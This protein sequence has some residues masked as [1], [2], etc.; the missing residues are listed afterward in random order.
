MEFNPLL[1]EDDD[2]D[3]ADVPTTNVV[4]EP[5]KEAVL[6]AIDVA[7]DEF[8][9]ND[10]YKD[11]MAVCLM[12][13]K[14]KIMCAP[15]D[16]VGICFYGTKKN[17][18]PNNFQ[19]IYFL[20][21]FAQN[22]GVDVLGVV[23]AEIER[24]QERAEESFTKEYGR[25]TSAMLSD[26]FWVATTSF[27]LAVGAG[28]TARAGQFRKRLLFFTAREFPKNNSEMVNARAND[29]REQ[30]IEL[31]LF[32]LNQ[33][34]GLWKQVFQPEEIQ[35]ED[36]FDDLMKDLR[37]KV[38]KKRVVARIPFDV[39]GVEIMVSVY[40]NILEAKI[41]APIRLHA[42]DNK[43]LKG[44]SKYV[45]AEHGNILSAHE[46]STYTEF[47]GEQVSVAKEDMTAVKR[48]GPVGIKLLG[49][50]PISAIQ[51]HHH[52]DHSYL[53][54]PIEEKVKGSSLLFSSLIT[55]M[56]KQNK[57]AIASIAMRTNAETRLAALFPDKK[58]IQVMLLP[59][60]DDIRPIEVPPP[61][62]CDPAA[63]AACNDVLHQ[64][65]AEEFHPDYVENV[66]LQTHH[67]VVQALA[68]SED[69]H[70]PPVDSLMPNDEIFARHAEVLKR[71]Q[72][73][74]PEEV[75]TAKK[76]RGKAKAKAKTAT[77]E[78]KDGESEIKE[79][80]PAKP[81]RAAAKRAA[82]K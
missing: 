40:V 37:K 47:G 69:Y 51:P 34:D 33:M 82:K 26:L 30:N 5:T 23:Q 56:S 39:A 45:N 24:A 81:K 38:C 49:F 46:I 54:Y 77:A 59:Y 78:M 7:S 6:L 55:S 32:L 13:L 63:V 76:P 50:R 41:P 1:E 18:N 48:Q 75:P 2:F 67:A 12:F 35:C 36:N 65:E 29:C 4:D 70:D 57:V 16:K 60:A 42:S 11:V 22:L 8:W 10:W 71:W 25:D 31:E 9:T 14:R 73:F 68:L 66:V 61:V 17:K 3:D 21:E 64:L 74:L 62:P 72:S 43:P 20:N 19:G 58:N 52:L 80:A 27:S 44:E 15:D 28:Q 53:L 79:E